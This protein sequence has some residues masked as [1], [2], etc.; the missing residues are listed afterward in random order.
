MSMAAILILTF[1]GVASKIK[2]LLAPTQPPFQPFFSEW[3]E[4]HF[5]HSRR[6]K[7]MVHWIPME[8][9]LSSC[10]A[11]P[12]GLFW[13]LAT[14]CSPWSPMRLR[15]SSHCFLICSDL[16]SIWACISSMCWSICETSPQSSSSPS[17][18]QLNSLPYLH[19]LSLQ[20]HSQRL[21]VSRGP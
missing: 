2:E 13:R 11:L 17:P 4:L 8:A 10:P 3:R 14:C 16:R 9:C 19:Q 1:S 15:T 7:V 21:L 6:S 20:G 12:L 5:S 18:A